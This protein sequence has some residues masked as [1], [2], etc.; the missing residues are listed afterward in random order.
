MGTA[1]ATRRRRILAK[2]Q[3]LRKW[4][5]EGVL[6]KIYCFLDSAGVEDVELPKW[7]LQLRM[8]IH[9]FLLLVTLVSSLN[10]VI[11]SLPLYA[12]L[13]TGNFFWV[14]ELICIIIYTAD[15]VLRVITTPIRKE[16]FKNP[17]NWLDF[18]G[19]CPYWLAQAGLI[20]PAISK[21]IIMLRVSRIVHAFLTWRH[22]DIVLI[23]IEEST[24]VA[25]LMVIVM[26]ISVPI[27]GL[28]VYYAERGTFNNATQV[29]ERPCNAWDPC[30][31]EPSPFQSAADGFWF[32]IN[33]ATTV[34]FGD[35][36]P[37]TPVGKAVAG[38]TM[39]LGVFVLAF[40]IMILA[41]NFKEEIGN[42]EAKISQIRARDGS[43][44]VELQ[45]EHTQRID[46]PDT[47]AAPATAPS[48]DG[49]GTFDATLFQQNSFKTI[50]FLT[51]EDGVPRR[52]RQYGK[53]EARYNPLF[54]LQR[55]RDGS[56]YMENVGKG[57]CEVALT[58]ILDS[59]KAQREALAV[60]NSSL[61]PDAPLLKKARHLDIFT[62]HLAILRPPPEQ[63]CE[64]LADLRLTKTVFN[65]IDPAAFSVPVLLELTGSKSA[66]DEQKSIDFAYALHRCRLHIT[67]SLIHQ[68]PKEFDI[69]IFFDLLKS[70]N[71]FIQLKGHKKGLVYMTEAQIL[72][73][74]QGIHH[75]LVVNRE[76]GEVILNHKEITKTICD[77]VIS[78]CAT[79]CDDPADVMDDA[80]LYNDFSD[81]S[82]Y[83]GVFL[84]RVEGRAN[85]DEVEDL[86]LDEAARA[87]EKKDRRILC[88]ASVKTAT[89]VFESFSLVM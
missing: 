42:K 79:L 11:E 63:R 55:Q 37:K 62:L 72:Y 9:R 52:I 35:I 51:T 57:R 58:L 27:G 38:A 41:V 86:T 84:S 46:E 61:P 21:W 19:L 3:K 24:E 33:V 53:E 56:V 22:Y 75:L 45:R 6:I 64:L 69:P 78:Q 70:T 80:F 32:F 47:E 76:E 25:M 73:H 23:T 4:E 36:Y 88:N 60:A 29:Y 8:V 5:D 34:G 1:K 65:D 2:K 28:G 17:M 81:K 54:F 18:L 49:S 50:F 74:L 83:Y 59:K 40:P 85:E 14:I 20:D 66:F 67:A 77:A 31:V 13:T 15:W 89:P 39:C 10:I 68:P 87:A 16:F 71:L 12:T 7:G 48:M 43:K 82:T 30:T 44:L 26:L